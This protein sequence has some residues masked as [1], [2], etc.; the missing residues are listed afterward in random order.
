MHE[1]A[2]TEYVQLRP[3]F[4]DIAHC[5]ALV[6]SLLEGNHAGRAFVDRP[7]NPSVAFLALTCEFWFVAGD[8]G[9]NG[10]LRTLRDWALSELRPP[11]G[12]MFFFPPDLAWQQALQGLF[13]DLQPMVIARIELDLDMERF[14]Q[15][16]WRHRVPAGFR[17]QRYGRALATGLGLEAFWGSLDRF[18]ARGYGFAV[19]HG[20]EVVSRCHT[21]VVGDGRA[22]ISIETTEPYRRQGLG[23]LAACAFI[24]HSLEQ[25]TRPV[26][27][28]WST[29][30]PSV[31]MAQKLGFATQADV[32]VLYVPS[33][34]TP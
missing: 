13:A 11:S 2:R 23:G 12:Q 20:D 18:L 15:Q 33:V 29:N 24:E 1:L 7:E 19:L 21:V 3:L 4:G 8:A 34:P 27:S 22:E 31:R 14:E 10:F 9:N 5:R 17:V 26:W 28:C 32:P 16:G 30:T 6:F 25:G